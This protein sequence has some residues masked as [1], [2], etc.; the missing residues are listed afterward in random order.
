MIPTRSTNPGPG[1]ASAAATA[2]LVLAISACTDNGNQEAA[3]TE[4]SS[5]TDTQ[6][7]SEAAQPAA[8]EPQIIGEVIID[9]QPHSLTKAHW[10][11][12]RPGF[13]SGT[14]VAIL[15]AAVDESGEVVVFGRQIDDSDSTSERFI[16]ATTDHP[17]NYYT[18]DWVRQQPTILMEDG[19][20]RIQGSVGRSSDD[21]VDVEAEFSLPAEPGFPTEC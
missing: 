3:S 2:L 13:H 7:E 5:A 14:T 12:P 16:R 8:D 21:L 1:L 9:G 20:A 15:V 6:S 4:G 11:E 18:S 17:N 19:V 10:C